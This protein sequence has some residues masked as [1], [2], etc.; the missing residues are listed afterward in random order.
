MVLEEMPMEHEV[1]S[2]EQET[3]QLVLAEM[4]KVHVVQE[5]V[6][7]QMVPVEMPMEHGVRN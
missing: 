4:P 1:R 7:A 6:M 5:R 3:A 2:P